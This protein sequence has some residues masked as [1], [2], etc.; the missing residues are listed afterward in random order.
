MDR[1]QL[2]LAVLLSITFCAYAQQ[3][4]QQQH[5]GTIASAQW[6]KKST[7]L[8]A[9]LCKSFSFLVASHADVLRGS[10]RVPA[11]LSGAGTPKNVCVGG[12]LLRLSYCAL[13]NYVRAWENWRHWFHVVPLAYEITYRSHRGVYKFNRE[14]GIVHLFTTTLSVTNFSV[15]HGCWKERSKVTR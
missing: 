14:I 9:P 7:V 2:L 5:T 4:Q 1:G 10:S 8:I 11:P 15:C 12:Y 3:Q 13:C 6:E